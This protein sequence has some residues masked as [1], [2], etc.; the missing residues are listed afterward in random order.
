[1]KTL[2]IEFLVY[3]D[4]LIFLVYIDSLIFLVYIDSYLLKRTEN[5]GAINRTERRR[6]EQLYI[7]VD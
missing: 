7:F 6:L 3:I 5:C 4:S 1:M 2:Q